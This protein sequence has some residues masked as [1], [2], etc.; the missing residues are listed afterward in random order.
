MC[1]F[2]EARSDHLFVR[3]RPSQNL[4][5]SRPFSGFCPGCR[6]RILLIDLPGDAGVRC[7]IFHVLSSLDN[8]YF[9]VMN[10]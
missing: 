5:F 7:V 6:V 4:S 8:V 10:T 3:S 9:S 2:R 1:S